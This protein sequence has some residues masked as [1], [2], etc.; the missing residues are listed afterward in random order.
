MSLQLNQKDNVFAWIAHDNKKV[1]TLSY[2]K[3]TDEEF[4]DLKLKSDFEF[5][6]AP[7]PKKELER[8]CLYVAGESRSGKSY[9]IRE[10]VKRYK[11]MFPKINKFLISYLKSDETIDDEY[12]EILR[13]NWDNGVDFMNNDCL[14]EDF[15]ENLPNSFV[16][17][18]DVDS[19]PNKNKKNVIYKL[20][21]RIL[22]IGRHE[23][24]Y[25]AIVSHEL[26]ASHELKLIL[27]ECHTITWFLPKQLSHKKKKYLMENYFGLSKEQ[28]DKVNSI[29]DRSITYI[30]LHDD[31]IVLSN[32]E[33]FIL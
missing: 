11:S 26:Y 32:K 6:L 29:Q 4:V 5:Q 15:F 30:K 8:I 16:I 28:I 33:C 13:I 7:I 1:D 27:N 21:H 17:M 12:K 9:F 10:Y 25:I 14:T 24:I 22:R 20:I 19:I 18:D 31:K 23:K 2:D 3:N